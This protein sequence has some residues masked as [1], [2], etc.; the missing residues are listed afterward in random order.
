MS[1]G[2]ELLVV[3]PRT[4]TVA[5]LAPRH[6]CFIRGDKLL[7]PAIHLGIA[8]LCSVRKSTL[9]RFDGVV[10]DLAQKHAALDAHGVLILGRLFR[11][12][13]DHRPAN[14]V[15]LRVPVTPAPI[16]HLFHGPPA[17]LP[18]DAALRLFLSSVE[19]GFC[20]TPDD[21]LAR[22]FVYGIPESGTLEVAPAAC[23][24][25]LASGAEP[26]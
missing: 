20:L 8:V 7:V 23:R 24:F 16:L 6:P 22:Q 17:L 3:A 26:T 13:L 10:F 19:M 18:P 1:V 21:Q 9:R 15:G 11:R 2:I 12:E 4:L 25:R 5:G 14:A